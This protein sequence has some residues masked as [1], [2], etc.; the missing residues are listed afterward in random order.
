MLSP[1]IGGQGLCRKKNENLKSEIEVVQFGYFTAVE[2]ERCRYVEL[3]IL[4]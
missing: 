3:N 4:I 2:G 1:G